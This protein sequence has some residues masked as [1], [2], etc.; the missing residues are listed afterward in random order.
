MRKILATIALLLVCAIPAWGEAGSLL[1]SWSP[2]DEA[3]LA[4]YRIYKGLAAGGP[5]TKIGEIPATVAPATP[6][7]TWTAEDNGQGMHYFT[8]TA[9]DKFGNESPRSNEVS[10]FV[11]TL[12]PKA[13]GGLT[14]EFIPVA[15]GVNLMIR[16]IP[17]PSVGPGK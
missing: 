7:F 1:L 3:D 14:I 16:P 12:P 5:Y 8:L 13:P 6:T 15:G 4:G 10:A 11:D 9:F 17:T 2:N